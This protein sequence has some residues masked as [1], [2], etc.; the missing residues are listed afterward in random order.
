MPSFDQ[1]TTADPFDIFERGVLSL[2]PASIDETAAPALP[3]KDTRA[4]AQEEEGIAQPT[5]TTP[6]RQDGAKSPEEE[7]T[8]STS[9]QADTPGRSTS[10]SSSMADPAIQVDLPGQCS[11][12]ASPEAAVYGPALPPPGLFL[13]LIQ[14]TYARKD[15]YPDLSLETLKNKVDYVSYWMRE[16][17]QGNKTKLLWGEY[18]AALRLIQITLDAKEYKI[19]EDEAFKTQQEAPFH[20]RE[21]A[22]VARLVKDESFQRDI[23]ESVEAWRDTV[24]GRCEGY[25]VA[26]R[27]DYDDEYGMDN[28]S[29]EDYFPRGIV[30]QSTGVQTGQ[31]RT[32]EGIEKVYGYQPSKAELRAIL[33]ES[34]EHSYVDDSKLAFT[35]PFVVPAD[36][37]RDIKTETKDCGFQTMDFEV[38]EANVLKAKAKGGI[39]ATKLAKLCK[40]RGNGLRVFLEPRDSAIVH[41]QQFPSLAQIDN[42]GTVLSFGSFTPRIQNVV[43]EEIKKE[44]VAPL[45]GADDTPVSVPSS[46]PVAVSAGVQTDQTF[47]GFASTGLKKEDQTDSPYLSEQGRTG[48]SS[49][50]NDAGCAYTKAPAKDFGLESKDPCTHLP[51]VSTSAHGLSATTGSKKRSADQSEKDEC[52][53]GGHDSRKRQ[54]TV[55]SPSLPVPSGRP[56]PSSPTREEA[57]LTKTSNKRRHDEST[58]PLPEPKRRRLPP[59]EETLRVINPRKILPRK[60]SAPVPRARAPKAPATIPAAAQAPVR[61]PAPAPTPV[62]AQSPAPPTAG[63]AAVPAP[64][65]APA[66]EEPAWKKRRPTGNRSAV[67]AGWAPYQPGQRKQHRN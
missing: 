62:P 46:K 28:N 32:P 67:K 63:R 47:S 11:D 7:T 24:D 59:V 38:C 2:A 40:K 21:P 30:C 61:A 55:A 8:T 58:D 56:G 42:A 26:S 66:S 17:E 9:S 13:E 35:Q 49:K 5:T 12:F 10:S 54:K 37:D 53:E 15:Y 27:T 50:G 19:A 41:S 43:Y 45:V 33:R 44:P 31:I 34:G 29:F 65:P 3:A 36:E 23:Q 4:P 57:V 22:L 16:A 51:R 18:M 52:P 48:Q 6:P 39:I 1:T 64:A 25:S 60:Q 14:D 20:R